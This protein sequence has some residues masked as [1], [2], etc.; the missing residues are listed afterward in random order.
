MKSKD[1]KFSVILLSLALLMSQNAFAARFGK[2]RNL[3]MQRNTTSYQRN[4]AP[5]NSYQSNQSYQ[6]YSAQQTQPANQGNQQRGPGVGSVVAGAAAGAVGGYML[7]KAMNSDNHTVAAANSVNNS[8]S[9][10]VREAA[11]VSQ[12]QIP[13][14]IIAIL[15]VLLVIGL[16]IFRR[17]AMPEINNSN[18]FGNMQANNNFEIPNI[19]QNQSTY[20]QGEMQQQR[21]PF[22]SSASG[23]QQSIDKVADGV[24]TQYFLR[25]AKGMFLHIQS[26][27]TP[28]NVSEVAKYMTPELYAEVKQLIVENDFVADFSQLECSLLQTNTENDNYIATV[29][30]YGFVS[31]APNTPPVKFSEIWHFVKPV[32]PQSGKWLVAGIQQENIN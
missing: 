10:V 15:G 28:E 29:R 12:S 11:P 3:G 9:Q 32:A 27:N 14:G 24:E 6:P 16:M 7:G 5:N 1:K 13:W 31:E 20:N 22:F 30:F 26:M 23:S 8:S 18:N 21:Q 2:Q 19:N 4:T 25:Q 17:R